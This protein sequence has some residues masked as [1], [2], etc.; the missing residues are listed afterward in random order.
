[1]T[2]IN[3]YIA[4]ELRKELDDINL[5]IDEK[6]KKGLEY[7]KLEKERLAIVKAMYA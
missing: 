1:M 6:I 2:N 4:D 7:T 3:E 5:A